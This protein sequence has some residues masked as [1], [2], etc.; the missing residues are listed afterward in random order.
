MTA[1]LGWRAWFTS[2]RVFDS[3]AV[4]WADLPDD[5]FVVGMVYYDDGTSRIVAGGDFYFAVGD[6]IA[7]NDDPPE[8]T[9]G[10]YP[11]IAIVRGQWVP[12]AEY[13]ALTATALASSWEM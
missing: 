12:D 11:G 2:G 3:A 6:S 4:A 8:V 7:Y 1:V 9:L 5:G 13:V 10:R